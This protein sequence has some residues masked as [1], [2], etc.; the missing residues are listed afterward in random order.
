MSRLWPS[1]ASPLREGADTHTECWTE[2]PNPVCGAGKPERP[3]QIPGKVH[4]LTLQSQGVP[5]SAGR[6][7]GTPVLPAS[8]LWGEGLTPSSCMRSMLLDP[9]GP[10]GCPGEQRRKPSSWWTQ[11]RKDDWHP[12]LI[13]HSPAAGS[14]WQAGLPRQGSAG[15]SALWDR[16]GHNTEGCGCLSF[17][18]Q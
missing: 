17:C 18:P 1:P 2:Q 3:F 10:R 6:P 9:E 4:D 5:L 14:L 12:S 15:A 8:Q 7:G 16:H 11:A 13:P